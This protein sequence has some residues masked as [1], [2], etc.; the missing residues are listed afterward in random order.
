M[1]TR[2]SEADVVGTQTTQLTAHSPAV[3]PELVRTENGSTA[4]VAAACWLSPLL[5]APT[6]YCQPCP[7]LGTSGG[8]RWLS[9]LR[10]VE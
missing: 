7:C 4:D 6:F 1:T 9:I 3:H 2:R 8:S 5:A 10:A